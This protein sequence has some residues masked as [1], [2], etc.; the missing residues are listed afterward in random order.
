M[1]SE[2]AKVDLLEVKKK[3]SKKSADLFGQFCVDS[4]KCALVSDERGEFEPTAKKPLQ[5]GGP[6][7]GIWYR[8]KE[9]K[10]SSKGHLKCWSA[11]CH[12]QFSVCGQLGLSF[13]M[14]L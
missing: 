14:L 2:S 7:D 12:C 6:N 13:C 3:K 5:C 1:S 4:S 9:Q 10:E 8:L 11:A